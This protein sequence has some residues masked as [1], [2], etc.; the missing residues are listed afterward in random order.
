MILATIVFPPAGII[1]MGMFI[2]DLFFGTK[3]IYKMGVKIGNITS[4]VKD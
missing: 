3:L 2:T 1:I 4:S